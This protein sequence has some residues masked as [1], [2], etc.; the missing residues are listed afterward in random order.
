MSIR[1]RILPIL[2]LWTLLLASPSLEA[3]APAAPRPAAW[4]QPIR[5]EGLPNLHR[6]SDTLYRGAQ[7]SEAGFAQLKALGIR[8]VVSLRAFHGEEEAVTRAGL[9]Y[10]SIPMKTWHP[11]TEDIVR[12]LRIVGDTNKTPVF[13]HCQ[14][15]ADRTGTMCALYRVF[16]CGWDKAAAIK[17]MTEGGYG[18]HPVWKNLIEFVQDLDADAIRRELA[19]PAAAPGGKP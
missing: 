1:W 17:E 8:T 16:T 13:V 19:A 15:G 5:R 12:F 2:A 6:I 14:H 11:E 7:P 4:A 18:F 10:T 3:E 9:S